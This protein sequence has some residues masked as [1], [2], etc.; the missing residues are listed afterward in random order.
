M[1]HFSNLRYVAELHQDVLVP[2][3]EQNV[4]V[5]E[6]EIDVLVPKL[7]FRNAECSNVAKREFSYEQRGGV[8]KFSSGQREG[9]TSL[10]TQNAVT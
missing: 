3:L 10:G 9:E 5:P 2:K 6:L 1:I 4:H 8:Y 7:L